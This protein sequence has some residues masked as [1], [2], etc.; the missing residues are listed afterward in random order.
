[1]AVTNMFSDPCAI[2]KDECIS[3]KGIFVRRLEVY[4]RLY[5]FGFSDVSGCIIEIGN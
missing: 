4:S 2:F 3:K 1:M 5:V